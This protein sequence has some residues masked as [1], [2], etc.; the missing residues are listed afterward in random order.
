MNLVYGTLLFDL[1]G[2]LTDP[3][4][5]IINSVLYAVDR[6]GLNEDDPPGL[7][8]YIGPPLMELFHGRYGLGEEDTWRAIR[9][10]REYFAAN[11]LYQNKVYKGV[12][13]LLTDLQKRRMTLAV[14]TSKP[15]I[16]TVEI[17]K[18]FGLSAYFAV[19]AGSELD[20][21][22]SRK[23]DVI[24]YA[25]RQMEPA[26]PSRGAVL[27]VG[28]RSHDVFGARENG[29]DCLGV[30]YGYGTAAELTAAGVIALVSTPLEIV[31]FLEE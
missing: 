18:H 11:G 9:Y 16:Y 15:L 20:G 27:M 26:A 13:E 1:D 19:V 21:S 31:R 22:R 24:A 7:R 25:L 10:Y 5:G 28:D 23:A 14:A 29:L 4:E 8:E 2:T 30:T 6:M 12:P 3:G 17:L